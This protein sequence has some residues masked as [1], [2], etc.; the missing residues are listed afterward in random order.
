[1]KV[2][3]LLLAGAVLSL[4]ALES[5]AG[6]KDNTLRIA[7]NQVPE[8]VDAYFNNVRIGVIIAHHVWDQLLYRDPK[9]GA[10]KP[11]LAKLKEYGLK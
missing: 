1:M 6:K 4:N 3:C 8:N 2:L 9:T 7:S 5:K 10:Y 11:L